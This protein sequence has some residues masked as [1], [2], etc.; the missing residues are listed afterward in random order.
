MTDANCRYRARKTG[1]QRDFTQIAKDIIDQ[2]TGELVQIVGTC[3]I[4]NDLQI[5][6]GIIKPP[7]SI[8]LTAQETTCAS[9]KNSPNCSRPRWL[10]VDIFLH[11]HCLDTLIPRH[12]VPRH[13]SLAPSTGTV[14]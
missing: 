10:I 6:N 12:P 11:L 1:K 7:S 13:S 2:V 8:W 5:E 3:V 9:A 4:S 14:K